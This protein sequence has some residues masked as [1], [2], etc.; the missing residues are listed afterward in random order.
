MIQ[1]EYADF[2]ER[3]FNREADEAEDAEAAGLSVED[4]RYAKQEDRGDRQREEQP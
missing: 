1:P 3:E 2:I 4:L